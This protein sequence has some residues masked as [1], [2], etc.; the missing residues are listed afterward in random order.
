VGVL[1]AVIFGVALWAYDGGLDGAWVDPV[2]GV[3]G[4]AGISVLLSAFR[5]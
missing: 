5:G 4:L 1:G 3:V 2:A